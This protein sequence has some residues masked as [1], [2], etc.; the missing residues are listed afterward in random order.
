MRTAIAAN[1]LHGLTGFLHKEAGYFVQYFEGSPD[2]TKQLT[3]NLLADDRH[4]DFTVIGHGTTPQRVFQNW[5]MGYS[6]SSATML[7]LKDAGTQAFKLGQDV[8]ISF[9]RSVATD[10]A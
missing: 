7:G 9:L 8:V 4:F 10:H 2:K 5:S 3:A 1:E 6:N